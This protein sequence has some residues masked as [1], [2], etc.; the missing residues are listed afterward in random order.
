MGITLA[1]Q[2]ELKYIPV[3]RV[4]A[5]H[6]YPGRDTGPAE[7]LGRSPRREEAA[8]SASSARADHRSV[9]AEKISLAAQLQNLEIRPNHLLVDS[10]VIFTRVVYEPYTV[11]AVLQVVIAY[12]KNVPC[13]A[14]PGSL[15]LSYPNQLHNRERQVYIGTPAYLLQPGDYGRSPS[16]NGSE[17]KGA[18]DD[19]NDG[20]VCPSVTR[21]PAKHRGF[22]QREKQPPGIMRE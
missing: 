14:A 3:R 13:K 19:P 9:Y 4:T 18:Q 7:R 21:S 20:P 16:E 22:A 6:V 12:P 5:A 17:T 8:Q 2:S 15:L 1:D 10:L 11:K